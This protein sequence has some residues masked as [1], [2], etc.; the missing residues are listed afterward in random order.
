MVCTVISN[1]SKSLCETPPPPPEAGTLETFVSGLIIYSK[2][3]CFSNLTM[4][5]S[6]R[7][8]AFRRMNRKL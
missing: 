1:W 2:V 3:M 5:V 7:V 6:S 4:N 8:L